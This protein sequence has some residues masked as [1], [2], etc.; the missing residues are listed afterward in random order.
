MKDSYHDLKFGIVGFCTSKSVEVL[1]R[2]VE[3]ILGSVRNLNFMKIECYVF[4]DVTN[5]DLVTLYYS[6]IFPVMS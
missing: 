6:K 1:S 5:G 3:R 2:S 4:I